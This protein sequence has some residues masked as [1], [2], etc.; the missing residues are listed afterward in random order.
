MLA[1]FSKLQHDSGAGYTYLTTVCA[2]ILT[3]LSMLR[4]TW[5]TVIQKDAVNNGRLVKRKKRN[6][7]L[8]YVDNTNRGYQ[9]KNPTKNR[10][11]VPLGWLRQIATKGNVQ[12][13]L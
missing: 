3:L 1:S 8:Q 11:N 13:L 6:Y 7:Y 10:S 2:L 5:T 4:G 12:L 9:T